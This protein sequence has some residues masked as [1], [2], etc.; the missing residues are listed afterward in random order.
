MKPSAAVSAAPP[1]DAARG[2]VDDG[3]FPDDLNGSN[4]TYPWPVKLFRFTSQQQPLEMAFMDVAPP[5][6]EAP[7]AVVLHGKNFCGPT[8]HATVDAL[9]AAGYRVVAPDQV[10]FC[11]SSKPAA[12]QFSLSQL[13]WN[14]RRLLDALGVANATVV[15]HS[16]GGMLAAHFAL[17]YPDAVDRLV[18]VAPVGLEDYV[19]Q[20]VP[21]VTV[22][23]LLAAEAAASY[24]SIHRYERDVYYVGRWRPAYDT[25]V[26]MLVNIYH[27]SR[28]DAYL[29]NQAQVVDMVLTSPVAHSFARLRPRTLLVVGDRDRTAIGSQWAP[30]DVAS[31]LG[32]FDVL[33]PQVA[34]QMPRC[35]LHR[36]ADLGH[37][38]QISDP[39]RFHD[40]LFSFLAAP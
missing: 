1:S 23:D 32:R 22:D 3:P 34:R 8:W 36:F 11:K 29:R 21:Y 6:R 17:Q 35:V 26:R 14:T 40:V 15:G 18:L 2:V 16:L 37:A 20:G 25:W 10:G 28:R 33:G 5:S 38:P 4:L 27:G 31:R 7:T 30:P 39:R 24:Q 12:Y 19:Q 9:A 13:A